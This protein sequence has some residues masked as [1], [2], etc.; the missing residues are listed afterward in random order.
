MLIQIIVKNIKSWVQVQ[1]ALKS[2]TSVFGMGTGVASSLSS[3]AKLSNLTRISILI[4]I[5]FS[6][7]LK[8]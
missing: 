1:S 2:L 4:Y 7:F 8:E 3:P 6:N 5:F